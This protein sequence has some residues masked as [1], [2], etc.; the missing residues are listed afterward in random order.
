[1]RDEIDTLFV[2]PEARTDPPSDVI[3]FAVTRRVLPDITTDPPREDDENTVARRAFP[4]T[5][6]V[7]ASDVIE[8][9]VTSL[10]DIGYW[11]MMVA[12]DGAVIPTVSP[13]ITPRDVPRTPVEI[14]LPDVDESKI[15]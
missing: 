8:Y 7:P 4:E 1:M 15:A 12:C 3:E 11:R 5:E 14:A 13:A 2:L 9:A 10:A 6:T